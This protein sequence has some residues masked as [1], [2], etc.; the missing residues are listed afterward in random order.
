MFDKLMNKV[1]DFSGLWGGQDKNHKSHNNEFEN[2]TNPHKGSVI[3]DPKEMEK[4]IKNIMKDNS[5]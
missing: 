5:K 3:A 1:K 4:G 2:N